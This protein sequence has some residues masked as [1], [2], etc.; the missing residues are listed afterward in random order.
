[1]AALAKRHR[2]RGDRSARGFAG[3]SAEYD[4]PAG[5]LPVLPCRKDV[6]NAR[7]TT[8]NDARRRERRGGSGAIGLFCGAI[9]GGVCPGRDEVSGNRQG[10]P[11][12]ESDQAG[13]RHRQDGET[14]DYTRPSAR[15][16][17]GSVA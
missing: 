17:I 11:E 4:R 12:R 15:P 5:A 2:I 8:K 7:R 13:K 3:I 16:G 14:Q 10:Q 6:G 9:P 1:M